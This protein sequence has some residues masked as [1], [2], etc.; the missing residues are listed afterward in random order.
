MVFIPGALVVVLT[1][2]LFQQ[3]FQRQQF[4]LNAVC[5][6]EAGWVREH[7]ERGLDTRASTLERLAAER[8]QGGESWRE[9]SR[10]LTSGPL[11]FRAVIEYDSTLVLR[12]VIPED[13]R[14]LS[15][16]DPRDDAARG[17]ALMAA[18]GAAG[19]EAVIVPTAPLASGERQVLVC[20]P[21]FQSA[22]RIGWVVGVVRL[23]DLL[24][25]ELGRTVQRG[26]SAGVYEGTT[27]LYGANTV[28][29][30]PGLRYAR[31]A[32]VLHGPLLW[33]VQVWPAEELA[34]QFESWA[35]QALFVAGMLLAFFVA[36]S[37]F[38][39]RR[40]GA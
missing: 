31:D 33:R 18:A 10:A 21:V 37:L 4:V 25:A 39:G 36:L 9:T 30:G 19:R 38:L 40:R 15:M 8:S 32:V 35:P 34:R 24:D 7:V 20:A 11:Q 12:G 28:D 29:G 2:A 27:L 22:A 5:D 13:L 17:V 14:L 26:F 1:F 23:R 3:A 16:L 6:S